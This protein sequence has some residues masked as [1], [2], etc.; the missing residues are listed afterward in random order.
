MQNLQENCDIFLYVVLFYNRNG[1][2]TLCFDA[3]VVVS[4]ASTLVTGCYDSKPASLSP[5]HAPGIAHNPV[6]CTI[7]NTPASD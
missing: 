1:E 7:F 2:C 3:Q 4:P 6:F 5:G